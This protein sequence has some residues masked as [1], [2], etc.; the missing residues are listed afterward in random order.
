M[1]QTRFLRCTTILEALASICPNQPRIIA[2]SPKLPKPP[3]NPNKQTALSQNPEPRKTRGILLCTLR[4][5]TERHCK[6]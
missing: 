2:D 4:A 3:T 6:P 1:A 5:N